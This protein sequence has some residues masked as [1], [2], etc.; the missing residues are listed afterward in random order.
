[1]RVLWLT[2]VPSP[3]RTAF[4]ELLG[5]KCELDVVFECAYSKERDVS[6]Q[7]F[8]AEH[9]R[10]HFLH[11]IQYKTDMAF[12][13]GVIH[14]LKQKYDIIVLTNYASL[15]GML[16]INYMKRHHIDFV[17]EGDGALVGSGTGLKEKLKRQLISSAEYW[18]ATGEM[19]KKYYEFYG[20]KA[21]RIFMYPFTSVPASNVL[22][23]PPTY[24]Q[25]QQFKEELGISEKIMVLSVGQFIHRKG[26]DI[27]LKAAE[28]I[29]REVGFYIVGGTPPEEYIELAQRTNAD[30]VHFMDFMQFEQLKLYYKA[31][32]LFVLPTREDIWG[33]VINEAMSFGLPVVT[34]DA[35]IAGIELLNDECG[36]IIPSENVEKL[37]HAITS[38]LKDDA[39]LK[40][41]SFESL[42]VISEYTLENMAN[43]HKE[44]F[45][46]IRGNKC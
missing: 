35:C 43:V 19:H 41:A 17:L 20:A 32:D 23:T 38:I 9:Y 5:K 16:A 40:N 1:M 29:D 46:R 22:E 27:L 3:Y 31:T 44:L 28:H 42:K 33:L 2:N 12:S 18:L 30:N 45:E 15:T 37:S 11:G 34:T 4:F 25:K 36:R 8:K 14:Y 21:D 24:A 13:F 39:W 10:A 6:W 7:K 26:Y